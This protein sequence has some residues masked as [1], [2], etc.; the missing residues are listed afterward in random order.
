MQPARA[1]ILDRLVDVGRQLGQ[2]VD[3]VRLELQLDL[4]GR[5]QRLVLLDQAGLGLGQD[6]AEILLGERGQA[7]PDRQAA[8]QL[9]QHVGRLGHMERAGADE[10]HVVGLHRAVL[11]VHRRALDQRQQ[12]ALHAFAAH[13]ATAAELAA[14][15]DL[16]D[17]VD[18]DDAVLLDRFAGLA[19][20]PLL[21]EELVA[22]LAHQ[23]LVGFG[24]RHLALLG[25]PAERLAQHVADIDH[26]DRRAGLARHLELHGRACIGDL[27]LD[28]TLG[29]LAVAQLVAEAQPRLFAGAGAAQRIEH[30]ILGG[31]L[32]LGAHIL[33]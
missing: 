6:A 23:G 27:D 24:H 22:L 29:K 30:A 1:D 9:G 31:K 17:L 25:A 18:E 13:V 2:L 26:A 20:D 7:D 4:L 12:V 14:G 21:V 16:V 33:A 8:L 5:Q 15:G 10:Q 11:C 3:G 32:G 28:L 19:H